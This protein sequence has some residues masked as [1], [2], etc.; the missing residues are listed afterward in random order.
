MVQ[1]LMIFVFLRDSAS[2]REIY[3]CLDKCRKNDDRLSNRNQTTS[4]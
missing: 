3:W 4:S 1:S 2:L